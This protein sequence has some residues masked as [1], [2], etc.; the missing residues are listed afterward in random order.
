MPGLPTVTATWKVNALLPHRRC[1]ATCE[2]AGA[3]SGE[4]ILTDTEE[5][6]GSNP[7]APTICTLTSGNAGLSVYVLGPDDPKSASTAVGDHLP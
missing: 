6:A 2:P 7:V 4:R 5:A 3:H 1:A